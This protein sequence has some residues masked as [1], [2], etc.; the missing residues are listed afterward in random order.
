MKDNQYWIL[1]DTETTGLTKPVFTVDLA[2][3]K[4]RGWEKAAD[5]FPLKC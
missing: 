2:A 4:M 5:F 3:Q 1:L